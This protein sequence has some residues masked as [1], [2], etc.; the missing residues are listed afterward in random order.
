M[1]TF[2]FPFYIV[3]GCL[4]SLEWTQCAI[5]ISH[6]HCKAEAIETCSFGLFT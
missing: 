1:E 4:Y 3:L 6:F 2:P 5:K